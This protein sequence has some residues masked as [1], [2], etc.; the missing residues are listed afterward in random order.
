[1]LMSNNEGV[2][3]YT[4]IG[5]RETPEPFLSIADKLGRHM[6][7]KGYLLR[8]GGAEGASTAFEKGCDSVMGKK[9]IFLPWR[10]FNG[11]TSSF[12]TIPDEA[13]SSMKDFNIAWETLSDSGKKLQARYALTILGQD[14]REPSTC[15]LCYTKSG[16]QK[17]G[18]GRALKIAL[19]HNVPIFD[20]G[21]YEDDPDIMRIRLIEFLESLSLSADGLDL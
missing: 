9:T 5:A 20:M 16:R 21:L 19:K 4:G 11:N 10:G 14:L 7:Q 15:V 13:Y 18:T 6:A 2:I 3:T 17:G 1:M 12:F 8:S